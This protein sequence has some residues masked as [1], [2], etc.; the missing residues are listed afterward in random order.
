M[1]KQPEFIGYGECKCDRE[2]VCP[3]IGGCFFEHEVVKSYPSFMN[4]QIKNA[5]TTKRA[6]TI[7]KLKHFFNE[8]KKKDS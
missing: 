5:R 4:K 3:F 6:L 7:L 1:P 2:S 8:H